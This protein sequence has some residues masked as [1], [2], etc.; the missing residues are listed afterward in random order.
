M[1]RPG[2]FVLHCRAP[3]GEAVQ[4]HYDAH[5]GVLTGPDGRDLLADTRAQ[6]FAPVPAVAP[7]VPARKSAEV[8]TLK[9]QL[10]MACN[11]GCSYCNQASAAAGAGVT[12]SA[13]ADAFL[14]GLGQWL[15]GAPRRIEFWGGEPLLYFAKLRRLVPTLRQRFPRAELSLVSNGSLLDAEILAFIERW[16]LFVAV[17]HDGP[18]QPLR[19][20]DPFGDPVRAH[21][22]RAL[23]TRRGPRGRASFNVVLTPDNT[24]LAALR[25][26]FAARLGDEDVALDLEGIV[27]VYDDRTLGGAGQWS[28]AQYER[29]HQS[30]VEAFASGEALR[31]RSLRAKARDFL[32]GLQARRPAASLG[33]KCGMDSPHELAVDLQGQV[34]TC[35]NTGAQGAHRLGHVSALA[36]VR[37]DTATHWSHRTCCRHCPVLALCRGGCMY[38]HGPHFAQTCE[39]EYRYHLAVLAGVL[40]HVTGLALQQIVGDQRRPQPARRIPVASVP[41]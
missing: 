35:Q 11:Y 34:M 33:Q 18:G 9:I 40:Q 30:I 12:R 8:D 15:H 28:P 21:W 23:W 41:G 32:A 4:L 2:F 1:S 25:R 36:E 14:D 13:D 19:G 16:D 26:W 7:Q 24:D 37:L 27:G 5:A 20:P 17:S 31:W 6:A 10:G 22:L 39:N 38:L 29:L 3:D